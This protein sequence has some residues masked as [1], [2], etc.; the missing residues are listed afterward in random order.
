MTRALK[1]VAALAVPAAAVAVAGAGPTSAATPVSGNGYV[2]VILD[3]HEAVVASQINA[4]NL[5]NAAFGDAWT[6]GLP[7]DSIWYAGA[8]TLSPTISSS[9][10]Q[11]RTPAVVS[12]CISST[13][14]S[15]RGTSSA[16]KAPGRKRLNPEYW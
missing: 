2:G 3:H 10:R 12:G 15:I 9:T 11:H 7:H 14:R 4:G 5:I 16:L 1:I 8:R 6:V 13:P